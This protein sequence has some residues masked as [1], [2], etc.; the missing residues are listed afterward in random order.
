MSR[1]FLDFQK[2]LVYYC[3][4]KF[5]NIKEITLN[6]LLHF[7]CNLM[8]EKRITECDYNDALN[9]LYNIKQGKVEK[10]IY[11]DMPALILGITFQDIFGIDFGSFINK[12]IIERLSLENTFWGENE[13]NTDNFMNYDNEMVIR[14]GQLISH[15]QKPLVVNDKKAEILSDNGKYLCGNAG[16]FSTAEDMSKIGKAIISRKLLSDESLMTIAT[17]S[18]ECFKQ[19]FGFLSYSKSPDEMLSE[20][21]HKMSDNAFA[22]SGFTG[23]YF[24]IDP[25]KNCYLFIGGNKLN[26]RVTF[27]DNQD[28]IFDDNKILFDNQTYFYTKNYVYMR[29]NLRNKCCDFLLC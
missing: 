7:N 8:T 20:I 17:G 2:N 14:N 6:E 26:N 19:R 24:M 22:M 27:T 1:L 15:S 25:I 23:T 9:Q 5:A 18:D 3:G 21:Y 29:D 4:N 10:P 13:R 12:E 11:S 28:L 16:L